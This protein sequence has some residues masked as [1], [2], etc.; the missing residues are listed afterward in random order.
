MKEE[1]FLHAQKP[2]HR[3]EGISS[4][5]RGLQQWVLRRQNGEPPLQSLLLNRTS[6]SKS[7]SQTRAH[8]RKW[9]QSAEAQSWMS[10]SRERTA[11]GFCKDILRGL[12]QHS[13]VSRR[14]KD[15]L[16]SLLASKISKT[17]TSTSSGTRHDCSLWSQR[18]K[19]EPL[20]TANV[21]TTRL[22]AGKHYCPHIARSLSNLALLR[23][24]WPGD[25]SFGRAHA[26]PQTVTTS[27][28]SL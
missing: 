13:W 21:A 9:S 10:G 3:W 23:V 26:L 15:T 4:P 22:W 27:S 1:I 12:V 8:S 6:Q 18:V 2:P 24:P 11:V 20:A 17:C 5:Q 25:S 7:G 14:S 16:N 19:H 28:G